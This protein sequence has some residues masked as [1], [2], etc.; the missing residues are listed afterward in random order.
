M[1]WS[2]TWASTRSTPVGLEMVR[3][4]RDRPAPSEAGLRRRPCRFGPMRYLAND[5]FI[6]AALERYGEFSPSEAELLASLLRPGDIAIDAGANIGCFT[7]PMAQRVGPGG[8]VHAFEPQ[9]AVF[10]LLCDNLSMNGLGHVVA[11]RAALASEAGRRSLVAPDYRRPGNFG[12]PALQAEGAG[13]AVTV[14]T[15]DALALPACRLIKADVQGMEREVL[16]GAAQ[17]IARHR[18]LLYLENDLRERSCA[19]LQA[20]FELGYR[21]YWHLP[22]V[23]QSDNFRHAPLDHLGAFVSVNL[24][25]LPDDRDPPVAGL[26]EVSSADDWW[27]DGEEG[28]AVVMPNATDLYAMAQRQYRRARFDEARTMLDALLELDPRHTDAWFLL[29]ECHLGA[30]R[31]TAA[32]ACLQ[33]LLAI[34]GDEPAAL[35]ALSDLYVDEKRLAEAVEAM[36]RAHRCDPS[37][38]SLLHGLAV[39]LRRDGRRRE[40]LARLDQALALAPQFDAARFERAMVLLEEGRLAEA[41]PD[42]EMRHLLEASRAAPRG[43]PCWPGGAFAGKRLL[44]TCEGGYGDTIWAARFLPAVREM[45]GEVFLQ[46]RPAQRELLSALQGVDGLT[47]LDAEAADFDLYCPILSLPARLGVRDASAYPPA[48]LRPRRDGEQHWPQLLARAAGRLRVGILWSGSETYANNRHRAATLKDFLPLL[49]LPSVQLFSLQ[50]GPQQAVLR[51]AGLGNLIIDADDC[52]FSETAALVE[53]LD[54]VVMTDSGVAHLA[55][56]L[57]KPVWL[58]LDSAPFWLFGSAGEHCPWYPTMRL[59]RQLEP[60]DWRGVI[61]RV[62]GALAELVQAGRAP[63]GAG[64]AA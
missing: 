31:R 5:T 56:S 7:L 57:G 40:A 27:Q 51:E 55:A 36:A 46:V 45:G 64:G 39:T 53:A 34:E 9:P 25:C 4:P 62:C 61:E 8:R 42:F 47:G 24:L 14:T 20:V 11:H 43:L 49:E 50:K 16:L 33:R 26:G 41:W 12:V 19:L 10:E 54:V 29:A 63:A 32:I 38:A 60:G 1:S 13:E 35:A 18:P 22:P 44:V 52:D 37:D 17:T 21:A 6:G 23:A 15:I 48:R 58:L 2:N 28:G 30:G 59:F 3:L